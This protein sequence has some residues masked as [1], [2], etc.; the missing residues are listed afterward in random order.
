ME[1]LKE[2]NKNLISLRSSLV[3]IIIVI[4]GGIAGLILSDISA[5]KFAFLMALGIY[6][7][8]M[9]LINAIKVNAKI[10]KNIGD[11]SNEH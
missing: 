7:D 10:N 9:F 1:Q 8:L 2:D 6:F 5:L 4:S 3:T 11:M